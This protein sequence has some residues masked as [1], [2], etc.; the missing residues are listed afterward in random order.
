MGWRT[1]AVTTTAA[2][3]FLAGIARPVFAD[4]ASSDEIEALKRRLEASERRISEMEGAAPT[5]DEVTLAV[6]KYLSGAGSTTLVGGADEGKAGFPLGKKPFIKEGSQKLEFYLRNQVRYEAFFYSDDAKGVL[7]SPVSEPSDACPRDRSGFEIERL[8]VG[9]QAQVFCEDITMKIELNFDADS[10][11][12]L[13]KNY[14]YLDWKYSGEHHVRAGSD[15]VPFTYEE[16]NS[17]GKLFFC[18]RNIVC[19]AFALDFDTGVQGWGYFGDCECPKRFLYR[20]MVSTGEGRLDQAGSVF[21][22]DAFD[23]YSDQVLV[24]GCFEWNITCKDWEY[25]EVDMRPCE[26]RC[27]LNASLGVSAYYEDDDDSS[28]K[29][30]GGFALRNAN[31]R[32]DRFGYNAWFRAQWNGW[33]LQAEFTG[34]SIDYTRKADGTKETAKDQ[35]DYGAELSINYRFADS[36]WGIGARAGILWVDDDYQT[37]TWKSGTAPNQ[38]NQSQ[39]LNDTIVEI[40]FGV[41]YYFW[42]HFDKLSLDATWI[43]DNSA[44]SSSSAGYMVG[45]NRGVVIEDGLMLR[46]QWQITL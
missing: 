43:Q 22:T 44:V 34:R 18:D 30:P 1:N 35:D 45:L 27:H 38:V 15:K 36:N 17:T 37:L 25:D 3:L 6:D 23:T 8:Y 40:A 33:S 42:D 12:G 10:A 7:S 5:K 19:K 4:G 16:Q 24:S 11:S 2:A 32:L 46:L 41:N 20:A 13:E 9:F 28:H 21:N 14:M 29:A 26:E 31:D 39:K